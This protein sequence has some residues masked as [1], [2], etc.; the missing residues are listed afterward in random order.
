M[1]S[2][3][4]EKI[5]LSVVIIAKN[6]EE[7]IGDC[8]QSVLTALECAKETEIIKTYE[9]ILS[10]SASTDRTIEIAKRYPIKILQLDSSWP[11]SCGAGVHIGLLSAK[12]RYTCIVDGDMTLD[13]NWFVCADKYM[14]MEDVGCLRGITKE[15]MSINSKLHQNLIKYWNQEILEKHFTDKTSIL[16]DLYK[17]IKNATENRIQCFS[18]GTLHLKTEIA[19]KTGGYN[20]YLIAA[21]DTEMQRQI[22]DARYKCLWIPCLMGTHY[23]AGKTGRVTLLQDFKTMFRNSKG[24]GQAARYSFTNKKT[25]RYYLDYCFINK[26]F[27]KMDLII[28]ISI[29]LVILN[30]ILLLHI[31]FISALI[32][33]LFVFIILIIRQVKKRANVNFYFFNLLYGMLFVM[34]R[35]FGFLCGFIKV[36]IDPMCYPKNP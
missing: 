5:D 6:E 18:C 11:L 30:W 3:T 9:V 28:S 35:Q 14:E 22:V 13:K 36:P 33:D 19:K 16:S 7:I 12:G 20:P 31:N 2:N 10:D 23:V 8:I 4:Q 15:Y 34:V 27:I 21:E 26:H 32:F 1:L 29:S 24:I 17:E 25:F